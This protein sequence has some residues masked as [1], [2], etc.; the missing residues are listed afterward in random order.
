[1]PMVSSQ[2]PSRKA[3]SAPT[4]RSPWLRQPGETP[5]AYAAFCL[6]RDQGP[7]HSLRETGRRYYGSRSRS[8][9]AGRIS[10]WSTKYRWSERAAAWDD[11][12]DGIKCEAQETARREM[13]KRQAA[14]ALEAQ[15]IVSAA[16]KLIDP[17]KM[18]PMEVL[19]MLIVSMGLERVARGVQE[20]IRV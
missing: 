19:R 7:G 4:D 17:A 11:E 8:G 16:M 10:A 1:A 15:A 2:T 13:D 20:A 9:R 12:L 14:V 6:Y 3:V 5:R 18:K